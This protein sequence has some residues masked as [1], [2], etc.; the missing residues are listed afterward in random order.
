MGAWIQPHINMALAPP[1]DAL[2]FLVRV[3]VDADGC[4]RQVRKKVVLRLKRCKL[5]RF[6]ES[7]ASFAYIWR[8]RAALLVAGP[9]DTAHRR[10]DGAR[11]TVQ[12]HV[13]LYMGLVVLLGF[14]ALCFLSFWGL[15]VHLTTIF[16]ILR[17]LYVSLCHLLQ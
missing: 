13:L 4:L 17:T 12:Q 8:S 16:F 1:R 14:Y 10:A 11:T 3:V 2:V 9:P 7:R 6:G 5:S 15:R